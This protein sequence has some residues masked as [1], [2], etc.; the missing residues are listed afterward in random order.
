[1]AGQPVLQ[2]QPFTRPSLAI[3]DSGDTHEMQTERFWLSR[4][5]RQENGIKIGE[6]TSVAFRSA[7]ERHF[8]GA[9]GDSGT[10]V[11]S[12]ALSCLSGDVL[13][14]AARRD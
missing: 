13:T 10:V 2:Q 9:K 6:D 3:I 1:M 7:K 8:R 4:G 12:P 14:N 5:C 11:D